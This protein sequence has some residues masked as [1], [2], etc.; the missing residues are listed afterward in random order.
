MHIKYKNTDKQYI[1]L[2]D[3]SKKEPKLARE[4]KKYRLL[5]SFE[6][7]LKSLLNETL[8]IVQTP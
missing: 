5:R 3:L 1:A 2:A 6:M 4:E 8:Y 7:P